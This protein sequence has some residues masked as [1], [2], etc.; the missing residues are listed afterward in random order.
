MVPVI[1]I[2][3]HGLRVL[4]CAGACD[5]IQTTLDAR[6]SSP[7]GAQSKAG[8]VEW[9]AIALNTI[10]DGFNEGRAPW[11]QRVA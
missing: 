8:P 9:V 5:G 1:G 6:R 3:P 10:F 2:R 4:W 11:R 7:D